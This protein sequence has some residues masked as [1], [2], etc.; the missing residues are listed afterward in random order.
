MLSQRYDKLLRLKLARQLKGE[1]NMLDVKTTRRR[2]LQGSA[3][4]GATA[5]MNPGLSFSAE[6]SV[7]KI[8]SYSAFQILDP[9]F[10]LSARTQAYP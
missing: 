6:G 5:M 8:R 4:L 7:L 1:I 2:F 9:A 3:A 10:T